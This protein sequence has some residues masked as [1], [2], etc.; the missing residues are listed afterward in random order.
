LAGGNAN[1]VIN[2]EEIFQTLARFRKGALQIL[3]SFIV[4][5][6]VLFFFFSRP[7]M[8]HLRD[9]TLQI[10]LVAFGIPESFLAFL[11]LAIYGGLFFSIPLIFYH[12][13]KALAPLFY[14]KGLKSSRTIVLTSIFLFYLGA[15]FCY[16]I[17]LPFGV[18][19]L[20]G[21]Q[22][23]HIKPMISVG[24]YI[25]FC[26]FFIFGFGLTFEL[27]LILALLSY[28]RLVRASFLT[29]N[30]RYA[31]LVIAIIAA[32]VTP[33]PD[34][35]NMSL[36]GAPLYILFEVGIILVKIIERKRLEAERLPAQG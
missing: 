1:V 26:T 23:A 3:I 18:Q 9:S 30:R 6:T 4:L 33:T 27:P 21:Y 7:L 20:L 10:D 36:M 28:L 2:R 14:R 19:F 12:L 13:W 31:V 15:F 24:K 22:S 8:R 16:F 32:V 5:A 35:F 25:S 29:R 11:K 17:T 34:V